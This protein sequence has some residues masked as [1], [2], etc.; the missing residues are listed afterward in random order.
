M[1]KVDRLVN[2]FPLVISPKLTSSTCDPEISL[3]TRQPWSSGKKAWSAS[4][5]F[6][7]RRTS[8]PSPEEHAPL[9]QLFY[10]RTEA[11]KWHDDKDYT[12][13]FPPQRKG[14]SLRKHPESLYLIQILPSKEGLIGAV[15]LKK[16]REAVGLLGL[17]PQCAAAVALQRVVHDM[18]VM[19][20]FARQDARPAGAAKGTS[21]NLGERRNDKKC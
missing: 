4:V 21:N 6:L 18:M 1:G 20:V 13:V 5:F 9:L 10:C 2:V 8:G 19:G 12:N 15:L 17:L 3:C 7:P 11:E 16:G 14:L